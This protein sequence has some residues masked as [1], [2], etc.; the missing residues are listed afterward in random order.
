MKTFVNRGGYENIQLY[1][2]KGNK[3]HISI[4][5]LVALSF[6][7]NPQNKPE[8]NH[9]DNNKLNNDVSNLEWVT[10][11]E[12]RKHAYMYGRLVPPNSE[13]EKRL[14]NDSN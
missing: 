8:V 10:A 11:S 14:E 1:D 4:H 5:R 2:G 9:I 13:K 3:S 7:D 12:N 6:I